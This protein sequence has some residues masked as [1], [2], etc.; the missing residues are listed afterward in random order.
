MF[1]QIIG[2]EKNKELLK[3][4]VLSQNVSHSYMFIYTIDKARSK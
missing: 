2:N 4:I 1:E 3:N